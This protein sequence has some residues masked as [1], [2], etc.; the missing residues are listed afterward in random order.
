MVVYSFNLTKYQFYHAESVLL[1]EE[2]RVPREN[3]MQIF[4]FNKRQTLSF[5][6]VL[7]ENPFAK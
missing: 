2:I 5:K 3:H 1:M 7:G 4:S 6:I